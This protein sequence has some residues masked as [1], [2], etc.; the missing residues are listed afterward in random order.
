MKYDII[1][2]D[3]RGSQKLDWL[4]SKFSFSFANYYSPNRMGF[5]TLRVLNDDIIAPNSGF[6]AHPH[7]N[8]EIISIVLEGEITH[9]DSM[10]NKYTLSCG[11][12]QV[13]SAG[14]G[15]IHSEFNENLE[16]E[17]K[18]LQIW[19]ETSKKGFEPRYEQKNYSLEE[20]KLIKLVDQNFDDMYIYQNSTISRLI[21][22][23]NKE[24]DY[25][26]SNNRKLYLFLIEGEI[27]ILDKKLQ[28]RDAIQIESLD[29]LKISSNTI[30]D[31]LF[32]ETV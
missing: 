1:K 16:K 31:I 24:F 26:I 30:S 21:L 5:G 15:I 8:M 6:G 13:M 4:D 2:S 10:G 27:E 29:K 22:D 28:T 25:Q 23:K 20:N 12:V 17:V 19:I 9:Q 3:S 18:M 14:T 7:A 32:N 11:D